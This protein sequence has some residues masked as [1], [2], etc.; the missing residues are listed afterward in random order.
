MLYI[1]HLNLKKKKEKLFWGKKKPD[2]PQ[3]LKQMLNYILNAKREKQAQTK[4]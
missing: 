3:A 1:V 2:C 4:C